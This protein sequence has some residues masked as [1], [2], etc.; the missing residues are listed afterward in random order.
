[1]NERE[2]NRLSR[3]SR[4]NVRTRIK[5]LKDT[6]HLRGTKLGVRNTE[7]YS[8]ATGHGSIVT[9]IASLIKA[10]LFPQSLIHTL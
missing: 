10:R 1:M 2:L 7:K 6:S 8:C 3:T 4:L 9:G 5:T